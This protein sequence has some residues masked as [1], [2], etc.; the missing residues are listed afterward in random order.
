MKKAVKKRYSS[1]EQQV[2]ILK[3][4]FSPKGQLQERTLNA[5]EYISRYGFDWLDQIANAS[6]GLE[7]QFTLLQLS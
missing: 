2:A 3:N 7:Q 1:Q 5:G 4:R 6:M